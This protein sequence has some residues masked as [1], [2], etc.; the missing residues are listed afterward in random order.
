V[1]ERL[2]EAWRQLVGVDMIGQAREYAEGLPEWLEQ[3][4][5]ANRTALAAT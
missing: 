3:E 1:V 2:T 4:V 5:E